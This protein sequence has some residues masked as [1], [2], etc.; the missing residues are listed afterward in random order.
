M[1]YAT[2]AIRLGGWL[3]DFVIFLVPLILFF[4]LFRHTHT[5]EVHLMARRGSQVRRHISAL[6]FVLTGV[7]YVIYGTVLAGDPE[8]RRSA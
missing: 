5:L 1:P 8:A 2:W 6:P 7:L 3:I 4:V